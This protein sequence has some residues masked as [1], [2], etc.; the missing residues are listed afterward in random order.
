MDIIEKDYPND[1]ERCCI[2]MFSKWLQINPAVC[3]EDITTAMDKVLAGMY[4]VY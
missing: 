1:C 3:W 4:V 2:K